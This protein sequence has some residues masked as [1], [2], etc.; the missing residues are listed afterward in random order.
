M[1]H[2]GEVF[3]LS[4]S[5]IQL[6]PLNT[7]QD[8]SF[9][10]TT[11]TA[12]NPTS[13]THITFAVNWCTFCIIK[14]RRSSSYSIFHVYVIIYAQLNWIE[15]PLHFPEFKTSTDSH[16][17]YGGRTAGYCR[18]PKFT[19]SHSFLISY[20]PSNFYHSNTSLLKKRNHFAV[21]IWEE[22][23]HG[24]LPPYGRQNDGDSTGAFSAF[25]HIFHS[26]RF[27]D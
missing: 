8:D 1:S 23:S 21:W 14:R 10:S 17:N 13:P 3:P 7:S 2:S 25:V 9:L 18:Q 6:T 24:R 27:H 19:F 12:P 5:P 11:K 22:S 15:H 4:T 26:R 16:Y 20:C